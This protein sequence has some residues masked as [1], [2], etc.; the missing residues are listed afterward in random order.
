MGGLPMKKENFK[1]QKGFSLL[2][3]ILLIVLL[4][5]AI[6][7]LAA[8]LKTNLISTGKMTNVSKTSFY[9]EQ[10]MEQVIADYTGQGSGGY[11]YIT[12]SGRY[13]AQ[14][15]DGITTTVTVTTGTYGTITY[16]KVTVTAPIAG[17][18]SSI[19]FSTCLP[20]GLF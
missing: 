20:N 14:T 13:P 2:E 7:P 11:A 1:I 17:M 8:L 10:R 19:S 5:I 6:P 18:N 16:A 9:A 3:V 4:G 12:T 15:V